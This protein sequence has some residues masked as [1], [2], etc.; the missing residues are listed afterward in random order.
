MDKLLNQG[1]TVM[2]VGKGIA[3]YPTEI[4]WG[5]VG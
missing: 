3:Y 5:T 2:R 1:E 4:L